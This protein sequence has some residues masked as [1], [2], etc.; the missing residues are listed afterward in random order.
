M[1]KSNMF[2]K[3]AANVDVAKPKGNKKAKPSFE[4]ADLHMFAALKAAS[5]SI[6]T[7]LATL[8]EDIDTEALDRFIL[9]RNGNSFEGTDGATSGSMQLRKRSSRSVLSEQEKLVLDEIGIDTEKSAEA[10][11]YINNKYAD[12]HKLLEKVSKALD[13]I[14]PDDFLGATSEKH[15]V[16]AD[17]LNQAFAKC[18]DNDQLRDV[19]KIV[20]TQACRVT[21]G[22]SHDEMVKILDTVLRGDEEDLEGQLKASLKK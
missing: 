2:Q 20:A 7:V 16:G 13:G 21:F 3:A 5:K 15:I 9:N 8:K 6:E 12:D 11:F 18:K 4:V 14:V 17:S 10:R 22:G 1:A 19:L